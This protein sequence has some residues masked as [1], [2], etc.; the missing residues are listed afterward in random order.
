MNG[1]RAAIAAAGVAALA[2]GALAVRT[3]VDVRRAE[4]DYPPTGQ[5]AAVDGVQLHYLERGSGPAVVLLHGNPGFVGDYTLGPD[6]TFDALARSHRVIAIDRPGHGYSDRPSAEKTTPR[7]Q[8]RLIHQLLARMGV[9]RPIIVGHSW[10]GGLA[11]IYAEQYPT[12]VAGLVLAGTRAYP[13]PQR[14]DPV[15]ALNR[16][17]V[18]GA[19]FRATLLP[20]IGQ[21]LLAS[22]LTAAYAPEPVHRDHLAAARALWLRP[23]QVAATVWDSQNLQAALEMA[24]A[25]YGKIALPVIILVGD[26]DRGAAESHRLAAAIAGAQL[27][28]LPN[29]G[30]ELPL[31]RPAALVEAVRDL[32]AAAGPR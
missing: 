9:E 29:A 12:D 15:Y 14:S 2:L 5:F 4:R 25:G 31:T 24:G 28:V 23:S 21:R 27:R 30:H 1:R 20:P 26:H 19:I 8:A 6:N 17:P 10:G 11:L 32:I 3:V 7:E 16:L 18:I 22:R 13:T